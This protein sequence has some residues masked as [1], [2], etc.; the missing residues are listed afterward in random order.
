MSRYVLNTNCCSL[1]NKNTSTPRGPWQIAVPRAHPS[2]GVRWFQHCSRVEAGDI[3]I[4]LFIYLSIH[5]F[6]HESIYPSIYV[7]ID[8]SL[9]VDTYLSIYHY[10]SISL[11]IYIYV[12]VCMYV[13]IYMYTKTYP[14][15]RTWNTSM[16][17]MLWTFPNPWFRGCLMLRAWDLMIN[18]DHYTILTLPYITNMI[19]HIQWVL[20]HTFIHDWHDTKCWLWN[21]W[22]TYQHI[23]ISF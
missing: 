13:Y 10:L 17:P 22:L 18:V 16:V 6:I 4:Y 14:I 2:W 5:L 21:I 15:P 23:T 7:P 3:C 9:C 20:S 11:S 19:V 1:P 12:Y 8:I